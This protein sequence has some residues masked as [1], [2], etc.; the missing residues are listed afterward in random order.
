MPTPQGIKTVTIHGLFVEPD[1]LGTPLVGQLTFTPNVPMVI[2]PNENTLM[3]GTE[4]AVLDNN[5]SFV[6]DLPCTDTPG[7]NPNGWVYTVTE[8]LIGVASRTYQILLPYT[9]AVVEL[10]DIMPT[11]ATPPG[12]LPAVGP[13]GPPGQVTSVNGYTTPSITLNS[14]DVGAVSLTLDQTVAGIKT[15]S[16][17][18]VVPTPSLA[19][20]AAPK[21]YVDAGVGTAVTLTG[22][23]TIGGTKT[24]SVIPVLPA[25]DPTTANQAARKSYID[26]LDGANLKLATA[27]TISG[28]KTFSVSPIVPTPTTGTQ[29]A[30]KAYVDSG[31]ATAVLLTGAQTVAGIKTFTDGIVIGA[32]NIVSSPK[33]RVLDTTDVSLAST[34][35]GFQIG[36]DAGGNIRM[37]GNEIMA[38]N[39]GATSNLIFQADG[40]QT[41]FNSGLAADNTSSTI[42]ANGS[43]DGVL[44]TS[45]RASAVTSAFQA[46]ATADTQFRFALRADGMMFW[47]PGGTTVSDTNLYRSAAGLLKT[48]SIFKSQIETAPAPTAASLFT[49][50]SCVG[51]RSNGVVAFSVTLTYT[52]APIVGNATTGNISD[53]LCLTFPSTW[54]PPDQKV[55]A[56][57]VDMLS[58]GTLFV[59]TDGTCVINSLYP[60]S[61]MATNSVIKFSTSWVASS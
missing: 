52:G 27:Q 58:G 51:R 30:T 48:D 45:T 7:Q 32:G 54:F 2:F 43:V 42:W 21:S 16:S 39:N 36:P 60:G 12:Y 9:V 31:D 11:P 56:I 23:Q 37:D 41:T 18:P 1:L 40:G 61:T 26:T 29:A 10:A 19:G 6:I 53:K 49:V 47:G 59:N 22:N 3:A 33:I 13:Q 15:F 57:D 8:K 50:T 55:E 4:T 20:Q 5:G 14:T 38:V 34:G 35:H 17:S 25:S 24:F 46:K 44:F 28:V